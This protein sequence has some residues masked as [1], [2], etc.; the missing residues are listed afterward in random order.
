M[1]ATYNVFVAFRG[2]LYN[3]VIILR[4]N[5]AKWRRKKL[6]AG[7]FVLLSFLFA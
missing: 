3:A 4:L 7:D 6:H 1:D 2:F 5:L